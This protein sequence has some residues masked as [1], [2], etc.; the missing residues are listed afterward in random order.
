MNAF[1]P[2]LLWLAE[3]TQIPYCTF[4][5]AQAGIFSTFTF[6]GTVRASVE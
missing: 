5:C 2:A 4:G 3:T 1:A 6:F